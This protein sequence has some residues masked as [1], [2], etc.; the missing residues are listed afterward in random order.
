ARVRPLQSR[1]PRAAV[2]VAELPRARG[3]DQSDRRQDGDA[4]EESRHGE[5]ARKGE[6][7]KKSRRH[8]AEIRERQEEHPARRPG[9]EGEAGGVPAAE[10]RTIEGPPLPAARRRGPP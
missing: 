8:E 1:R 6:E 10:R 4:E 3:F 2:R 9:E 5:G 7:E